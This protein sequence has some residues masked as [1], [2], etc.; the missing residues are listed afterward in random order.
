MISIDLIEFDRIL[1][2]KERNPP[3]NILKP[4][5]GGVIKDLPRN[6]FS[7]KFYDALQLSQDI[8]TVHNNYKTKMQNLRNILIFLQ[9]K[10]VSFISKDN[11]IVI[12]IEWFKVFRFTNSF[13]FEDHRGE[14]TLSIKIILWISSKI[15][16]IL[17]QVLSS[18][19]TFRKQVYLLIWP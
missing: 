1:D 8:F 17:P 3:S 10:Y 7:D 18:W 16:I 2:G 4:S 12:L 11:L 6:L 15:T 9:L 13:S 5:A 19:L 14:L